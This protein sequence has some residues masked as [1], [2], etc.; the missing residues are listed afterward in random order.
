[1]QKFIK[2]RFAGWLDNFLY[3]WGWR[4]IAWGWPFLLSFFYWLCARLGKIEW[5]WGIN[6]ILLF[7]AII[8]ALIGIFRTRPQKKR[9]AAGQDYPLDQKLTIS[10]GPTIEGSVAQA[11][12][13]HKWQTHAREFFSRCRECH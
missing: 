11:W 2:N 6:A 12:W 10:S 8:L 9:Q 5:N 4:V 1:M 3:D 7:V 13:N